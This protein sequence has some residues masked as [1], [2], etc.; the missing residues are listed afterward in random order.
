MTLPATK[1]DTPTAF[2]IQAASAR[3][4]SLAVK[5]RS[6]FNPKALA[7]TVAENVI[8]PLIVVAII[9]AVWQM[10][11]SAPGSS[12]PPP[13]EVWA[14]SWD[15]IID[16]FF[17]YGTQDIG[18]GWRVLTSLERVAYGFGLAAIVGIVV[19]AIIGQSIWVMRGLDPRIQ[20]KAHR[21]LRRLNP[22]RVP[23]P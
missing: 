17:V 7:R 15:L 18:L 8:P 10:L 9:L 22:P 6:R 1:D 19:G 23:S 16:P 11:F 21:K 12:L 3:I 14:Q 2:P 4:L 5:A 13:S 20:G